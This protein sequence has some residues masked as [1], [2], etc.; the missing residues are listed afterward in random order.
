MAF[1][2]SCGFLPGYLKLFSKSGHNF[3][4]QAAFLAPKVNTVHF[5][6]GLNCTDG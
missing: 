1:P 3:S 5:T 6:P 4:E 2:P